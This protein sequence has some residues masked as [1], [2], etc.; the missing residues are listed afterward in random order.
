[1]QKKRIKQCVALVL[2]IA[3]LFVATVPN[4]YLDGLF[5][6][7]NTETSVE[8]NANVSHE[9]VAN[10]E[11]SKEPVSNE[12]SSPETDVS[13]SGDE[14]QGEQPQP[15]VPP[16]EA[17][18][19]TGSDVV[20]PPE[21][22]ATTPDSGEGSG[23]NL[24]QPI[25]G[26]TE[27]TEI[28]NIAPESPTEVPST[29]EV[30]GSENTETEEVMP[31][32]ST[33]EVIETE[34]EEEDL[35]GSAY[36]KVADGGYVL[37]TVDE[38][39]Y[40]VY[41]DGDKTFVMDENGI[42]VDVTA[43]L[44][45][46]Y[47]LVASDKPEGTV[48]RTEVGGKVGY[49]VATY[50]V[51]IDSGEVVLDVVGTEEEPIYMRTE[52]IALK[53]GNNY[54]DA[55]FM[56][57]ERNGISDMAAADGVR[58]DFHFNV[59]TDSALER[60]RIPFR[61]YNLDTGESHVIVTDQNGVFYSKNEWHPH[62]N[63]TNNNDWLINKLKED[64]SYLVN[65]DTE[66]DGD[67]GIWFMYNQNGSATTT[68]VPTLGALPKGR[69]YLE[70]MPNKYNVGFALQHFEFEIVYDLS[71]GPQGDVDLGTI[72][73]DPTSN[74]I[75]VYSQALST[76]NGTHSVYPGERVGITDTVRLQGL[77]KGMDYEVRGELRRF[78]NMNETIK[79][80][81]AKI[82]STTSFVATDNTMECQLS[83][84]INDASD[85]VN[86]RAVVYI[87]VYRHGRLVSTDE[88]FSGI[89]INHIGE[90]VTFPSITSTS[91]VDDITKNHVG[92]NLDVNGGNLTDTVTYKNLAPYNDQ[93]WVDRFDKSIYT[94]N[95]Q[96]YVAVGTLKDKET[97]RTI[98][99]AQKSF[100]PED[101]NG[102]VDIKYT[103][104][105]GTYDGMTLVS[106]VNITANGDVVAFHNDLT[107]EEQ[108]VHF[109]R[110]T[111]S[112]IDT[113]TN[114]H[115]GVVSNT[116][117]GLKKIKDT[118]TYE[119]LIPGITY[120][121]SG[122]LMCQESNSEMLA[123]QND[124]QV[125]ATKTFTPT[126]PNGTIDV[127]FTLKT[128]QQFD[129]TA[130]VYEWLAV[131]SNNVAK[132]TVL[133]D[134]EQAVHYP[135]IFTGALDGFT[136]DEV[137]KAGTTYVRDTV[138]YRNLVVGQQYTISGV[139]M[140]V[141]TRDYLGAEFGLPR[142]VATHTFTADRAD[143]E[144]EMIFNVDGEKL[145]G[146]TTVAFE[147]LLVN[148]II[149]RHHEDYDD[150]A[151][152]LYFP[153][154]E[155]SLYSKNSG[156]KEQIAANTAMGG[157]NLVLSDEVRLS[158]L[159]IGKT[160]TIEGTL[161]DA[162]TSLPLNIGGRTFTQSTTFEA[163]AK[164]MTKTLD[165]AVGNTSSLEGK[166]VVA[167]ETLKHNEVDVALHHS[168]EDYEQSVRYPKLRTSALSPTTELDEDVATNASRIKD[169]IT[170]ENLENGGTY[171]VKGVL[172]NRE[173]NTPIVVDGN[174][175]QS[176]I[177]FV[178]AN[179]NVSATSKKG[180][181]GASS[182]EGFVNGAVTPNK[183]VAWSVNNRNGYLS[184]VTAN[185]TVDIE[186][187][188]DAIGTLGDTA[189]CYVY[190]YRDG[191][192]IGKHDNL[193]DQEEDVKYPKTTSLATCTVTSIQE[194]DNVSNNIQDTVTIEN[195]TPGNRYK[196]VSI[197]VDMADG[198]RTQVEK[199]ITATQRDETHVL[200]HGNLP[201]TSKGKTYTFYDK[202]YR[203]VAQ[204][205]E[206]LVSNHEEDMDEN[207]RIYVP[208]I[209]T[210][211][212]D[213]K[214]G[215]NEGWATE[216][217]TFVDEVSYENLT[218]G[219]SYYVEGK[220][221]EMGTNTPVTVN[222]TEVTA[223]TR[224]IAGVDG[225][226][227][228]RSADLSGYAQNTYNNRGGAVVGM[229][230]ATG[231][232]NV[233]FNYDATSVAGKNIV[234]VQ[235]VYTWDGKLVAHHEDVNDENEV[236]SYPKVETSISDTDNG[237]HDS[238]ARADASLTDVVTLSNLRSRH[239]YKVIG[240]LYNKETGEALEI[241]GSN[242]TA[243][244]TIT[245]GGIDSDQSR[246][247][248]EVEITYTLDSSEIEGIDVVSMV[249]LVRD[250]SG[251]GEV[252]VGDHYDIDD[253]A[254]REAII[255]L[256][257][258]AIDYRTDLHEGLAQDEMIIVDTVQFVNLYYPDEEYVMEGSLVHKQTGEV[259]KLFGGENQTV[260][261]RFTPGERNGSVELEFTVN[262]SDL[263][264][265]DIVCY[266]RLY[267][268]G[269]KVAE[270]CDIN[271]GAETVHVPEIRTHAW[272]SETGDWEGWAKPNSTLVDTIDY[273]NLTYGETYVA[274]AVVYDQRA[275]KVFTVDGEAVE[276]YHTFIAGSSSKIMQGLNAAIS[277][278]SSTFGIDYNNRADGSVDVAINFDATTAAGK[279]LVVFEKV[280]RVDSPE[281][282]TENMLVARH[283]DI[284]DAD[285][286]VSYPY[287]ETAIRD[288]ENE[289]H[290]SQARG[291]ASLTD[292]VT[293]E[294]LRVGQTYTLQGILYDKES[295]API[296]VD[297]EEVHGTATFTTEERDGT[298]DVVY[299]FN[300]AELEGYDLVSMQLLKRTNDTGT[301]T[302]GN[303][304]DIEDDAQREAI[305][306]IH[307]EAL[308]NKTNSH[309]NLADRESVLVDTV[310]YNNLYYPGETYKLEAWLV[311]KETERVLPLYGTDGETIVTKEFTA[312]ES[313]SGSEELEFHVDTSELKNN[314]IVA[315]A[316]LYKDD[317]LIASH[318]DLEDSQE[319][320]YVPE[321]TAHAFDSVTGDW[322]GW[323]TED[324]VMVDTVNYDNLTYGQVYIAHAVV[325]D[326]RT[327]EM[328]EVD[329]DV[330]EGYETFVA[331]EPNVF[332]DALDAFLS[333]VS[334]LFGQDYTHRV[335]G[336]VNVEIPF[337]ASTAEGKDLI[338]FVYV[339]RAE[340]ED[341]EIDYNMM[342][343][344]LDDI[345]NA[346]QIVSYP[347]VRTEMKDSVNG[348][349]DSQ[350]RND[351]SLTDRVVYK[352]LRVGQTYTFTGKL[353]DPEDDSTPLLING[354]E[355]VG[356]ATFKAEER[357]GVADVVYTFDSSELE[358]VDVVSMEY[359]TRGGYTVGD[360][361]D[362]S[363][364]K[365]R[366]ANINIHTEALDKLT[367]THENLASDT[368]VL[369]DTVEYVN[370]YSPG[371]TYTMKGQLIH[372]QTGDILPLVGT[373]DEWVSVDFVPE[374]R[375]GDVELEFSVDTS[376]LK[377]NDIVVYAKL[378]K[379][380][381]E[382][383]THCDI[384][385]TKETVYIPE[386]STKAWDSVT[387]DFEGYATE[388]S[389][390]VDTINYE[391]LTFGETYIANAVLYDKETGEP[392]TIDG[393]LVESYHEFVAGEPNFFEEVLDDVV[394]TV[395]DLLDID[396]THRTSGTVDV[397]VEFDATTAAGKDLVVYEYVY[398]ADSEED[399]VFSALVARHNDIEDMNQTVSYPYLDTNM[400][401]T[402]AKTHESQAEESESYT[403]TI[404]Y[405]KLRIGEEYTLSGK[406]M[407]AD[408]KEP[409][410]IG[411]KEVTTSKTFRADKRDG[412]LDLMYSFDSSRLEGIDLVSYV[413]LTRNEFTTGSH[414][415]IS[416]ENQ[417]VAVINSTSTIMDNRTQTNESLA[418]SVAKFTVTYDY[419]NLKDGAV[420]TLVS[421]L[422]DRATGQKYGVPEANGVKTTEFVAD[423]RDNSIELIFD[424]DST[425]L[426]NTT[427]V[428]FHELY[429]SKGNLICSNTDITNADATAYIPK[430][431]TSAIDYKS[432][433]HE[434]LANKG[435]K[436]V[437]TVSYSNLK[438]GGNY[439]AYGVLRDVNTGKI[440]RVDGKII[441]G[442]TEFV[443]N[444][445]GI[446]AN[447]KAVRDD[448]ETEGDKDETAPSVTPADPDSETPS[449]PEDTV[450]VE[451]TEDE[452]VVDN[453]Y[454]A[455][456]DIDVVIE[457]DST[458]LAGRDVVV[459]EYIYKDCAKNN[460]DDA[461]IV[462]NHLDSTDK[463]QQ[464]SY[465]RISTKLTDAEN[466][467]QDSQA[468]ANA[469]LK[470]VVK[471]TNLVPG[472]KYTLEGTLMDAETEKPIKS[473]GKAVTSTVTFKPKKANGTTT[474]EFAFDSS[475]LGG[476]DVVAFE[477]LYSSGGTLLGEHEDIEDANQTVRI[478]EID[479][480]AL[481][482]SSNSHNVTAGES[483]TV[484][485]TVSYTNL[486]SKKDYLL[487]GTLYNVTK[488]T[489]VTTAEV[490][491]TP[492][493][494]SGEQAVE[495]TFNPSS[496]AGDTLV[497]L[498]ELYKGSS[499]V[500]V[501]DDKSD[502]DQ[503]VKVP[504]VE[505]LKGI[506]ANGKS[507]LVAT[508]D[509]IA[510]L[511]TIG[512]ILVILGILLFLIYGKR[513]KKDE[514]DDPNKDWEDFSD[515]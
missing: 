504:T 402:Q 265:Q 224:F 429:D 458:K 165:F 60:H 13:G 230:R 200:V 477:N 434:G 220:L 103:L 272:D 193:S 182:L 337:D 195:L 502:E 81:G 273:K 101:Y 206:R 163:T 175:P 465:P 298:A 511:V 121:V 428:V 4:D 80:N 207:Q 437:D 400:V 23:G 432:G 187:E 147:N 480:V 376:G 190:L 127:E 495:F 440:I 449:V 135:D 21:G 176:E 209:S 1:M 108:T 297:G 85:L 5:A 397:P 329:G 252:T 87:E 54:I 72:T 467:T 92:T 364:D 463:L 294:N 43:N 2:A 188:F 401:D 263:K 506:G 354:E 258:E 223:M 267:K 326:Q 225:E 248:D 259:L 88:N 14:Q 8:E 116:A 126:T 447:T 304:E 9:E 285:Q 334:S 10:N 226:V 443:A 372:R 262:S 93:T 472:K 210:R 394:N 431:T 100:S 20:N 305:I 494:S 444:G 35:T 469:V 374:D 399:C 167:Y 355:V 433:N 159:V 485:D 11:E 382:I 169:T 42:A 484:V 117:D 144:I 385:D 331:G 274:Y 141:D 48:I 352:N 251:K 462:A 129:K 309:E 426:A 308:D 71:V 65:P 381:A 319:T 321:I 403:D 84:Q 388:D 216:D 398:R 106:T 386:I 222:G 192:C 264:N 497:V 389:T 90:T 456:G 153:K 455:S 145:Q 231:K 430:I 186:F 498:E 111:T 150:L 487:K 123:S 236:V 143:G 342:V 284:N 412:K 158:N 479:T 289:T 410:I 204:G 303:H 229:Q 104:P 151:Q 119:N 466:G 420:Y 86:D 371:E 269:V 296:L 496:C 181:V 218:Y 341:D 379:G 277:A 77:M 162:S 256:H 441:S 314:D 199:L 280:Y 152:T 49:A 478:I 343:A 130:V 387:K 39:E 322:E 395:T 350:V 97:G 507:G 348:T 128:A 114:N 347:F 148:G 235:R 57:D 323:A 46:G 118:V 378:F 217:S 460:L 425:V 333:G 29:E 149:V 25:V 302:V 31:T 377:N 124:G 179:G 281:D 171:T 239:S 408:T 177:T 66:L 59:V 367:G 197:K 476:K 356:T 184:E 247:D 275:G 157:A 306:D 375:D 438:P 453:A 12:P 299:E 232:I 38:H 370:L 422:M 98:T 180:S 515:F 513:K 292:T 105:S 214:T 301:H 228:W 41:V 282:I 238:Q 407:V 24:E 203:V 74:K 212:Y 417:T 503:T 442:I 170:F 279:D 362:I 318:E 344:R 70:E 133:S 32:E 360:H 327:G 492:A 435:S 271:D 138:Y 365:Q 62:L 483:A 213:S 363:D 268:D 288:T 78:N 241:N 183:N 366:V 346:D 27:G 211:A 15:E 276:T 335:S 44:I 499:V 33:E 96:T 353:Y 474:V 312:D 189:V 416:D 324:S 132:H 22:D 473:N 491:F 73:Q 107:D 69:Y 392:F 168:I 419:V 501:H 514:E 115:V 393:E 481:D 55:T 191:V 287:I 243:T 313:R 278:I 95:P 427:F 369:V 3:T 471:Y 500:A 246:R 40:M 198:S 290:D 384:E 266:A 315:Y 79:N 28:E 56:E 196:I 64:S 34:T 482:K 505:E 383:A 110:I 122:K 470:D 30:K 509:N 91:L 131:G 134:E 245:G 227:D 201:E 317:V 488:D 67:S 349:H 345:D 120:K 457:Y 300:S 325:Y 368:A 361:T 45:D 414:E 237:T 161:Y 405:E 421:T 320:I 155:T 436:I 6:D 219:E 332:G 396:Y 452:E 489:V 295:N 242:V 373:S 102:T 254:Q 36:V 330:V 339:Y 17:S 493:T 391:N 16:G 125:T 99:T 439:V 52:D 418:R 174:V 172:Y 61:L 194:T 140:D 50:R 512:L 185:G 146:H 154:I 19:E 336:S 58:G 205:D 233:N 249:Y 357:D 113:E 454:R 445:E 109:P 82:E 255:N 83:F 261:T 415:D 37:V 461:M 411:G 76:T 75:K 340:S 240:T 112:A 409:L 68:P 351:S 215:D 283:E 139:L 202:V 260:S 164:Q 508:G 51:T 63:N 26:E 307:T 310:E 286:T 424:M 406:L 89:D 257:T 253:D 359:L 291:N 208:S 464:V 137:I 53:A 413:T 390:L 160:Y 94:I 380:D 250:I 490:S 338:P 178:A 234:A 47:Y 448:S 311:H 156:L 18:S 475:S 328:F 459:Y 221:Y 468:R 136:T 446:S 270:H 358:G 451:D 7:E 166:T 293:Y 316:R 423:G 510:K 450:P 486:E 244:G 173:K 142:S 404:T